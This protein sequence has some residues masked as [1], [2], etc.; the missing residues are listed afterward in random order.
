MGKYFRR[1][2]KKKEEVCAITNWVLYCTP[3][4]HV[5]RRRS[6]SLLSIYYVYFF[7]DCSDFFF[8]GERDCFDFTLWILIWQHPSCA[9]DGS[10]SLVRINHVSIEARTFLS[11]S[12]AKR[13]SGRPHA[14]PLNPWPTQFHVFLMYI[15]LNH[16]INRST[17]SKHTTAIIKNDYL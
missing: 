9:S 13:C 12:S 1:G 2:K 3:R 17:S 8:Y 7:S 14:A 11:V 6:F 5:S 4:L 15:N 16:C 10:V